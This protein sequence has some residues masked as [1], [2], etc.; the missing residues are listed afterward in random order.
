VA[1]PEAG[2]FASVTSGLSIQKV[3]AA[4]VSPASIVAS[5]SHASVAVPSRSFAAVATNEPPSR[6]MSSAVESPLNDT[7]NWS[8]S[9]LSTA[10]AEPWPS[11]SNVA[12]TA[13]ISGSA[14]MACSTLA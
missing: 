7:T 9:A 1:N 13:L 8:P 14:R 5:T 2:T 3:V 4:G 11:V 6:I 12:Y 10:V